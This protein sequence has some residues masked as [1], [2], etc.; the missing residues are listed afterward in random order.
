MYEGLDAD[1]VIVDRL[2][3]PKKIALDIAKEIVNEIRISGASFIYALDDNFFDIPASH[4]RPPTR[5]QLQAVD[6]FLR[7]ANVVWV[8]TPYLQE[9]FKK[10]NP[11][12]QILPNCLDESL[13][14]RRSP[15][16]ESSPFKPEKIII[17]YMGTQ[18][19]DDDLLMILPVLQTVCARHPEVEIQLIGVTGDTET[20][21][22]LQDMPV[23][24]IQ[25]AQGEE[26]YPNFMLWYTSWVSWDIAIAPLQDTDFN[27]AKSDIKFLDYAVIGAAGI[28]SDVM[29]YRDSVIHQK[30]GWLTSNHP[31]A[32]E[33]A[34]ETLLA[35]TGTRV[36]LATEA[37]KF[38]FTSR[39][40]K[41]RV[42]DWLTALRQLHES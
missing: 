19:H 8:T 6:Y 31:A 38:V 11:N 41:H 10:Y 26:I 40:L 14:V 42:V 32:W 17:G 1:V 16:R 21:A 35:D 34:L 23:R 13:L 24:F 18:T 29:A 37:Q 4:P 39:I 20:H 36:A 3:H 22:R 27:R 25:P 2:W 15:S 30:N 28:Y 33:E 5:S 12:I 7:T 9:C